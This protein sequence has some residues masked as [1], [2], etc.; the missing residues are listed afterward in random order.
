MRTRHEH[1][2][3]LVELMV[4][5]VI[6]GTLIA[7]VG[8]NV[9]NALFKANVGAAEAQMATFG[10]AIDRYKMDNKQL[11]SALEDLTQTDSKNPYPYLNATSIPLDPWGNAYEYRVLDAKTFEIRCYGEDGQPDT[12]DDLYFPKR[13]E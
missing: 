12:E 11:P 7:L 3:T 1:G 6:L 8:P 9:Y 4:V 13:E 5:I 2:F 10:G